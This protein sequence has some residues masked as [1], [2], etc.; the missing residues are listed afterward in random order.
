[1][2]LFLAVICLCISLMFL[3]I[4]MMIYVK[5]CVLP[6]LNEEVQQRLAAPLTQLLAG[7]GWTVQA[8]YL[9]RNKHTRAPE[10]LEQG[11]AD[12][13][14]L[15]L[16]FEPA[17]AFPVVG[18]PLVANMQQQQI[19][20]QQQQQPQLQPFLAQ[21]VQQQSFQQGVALGYILPGGGAAP[22]TQDPNILRAGEIQPCMAQAAPPSSPYQSMA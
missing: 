2:P 14:W 3:T 15:W 1:M 17:A 20:L 7:T 5:C 19:Q 13:G 9:R 12:P 16:D 4:G 21:P 11:C 18:A 8:R 22:H 6:S 10:G